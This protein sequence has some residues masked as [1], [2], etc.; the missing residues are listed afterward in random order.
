MTTPSS[1]NW[2]AFSVFLRNASTNAA[3]SDAHPLFLLGHNSF[4]TATSCPNFLNGNPLLQINEGSKFGSLWKPFDV[5][6]ST[7]CYYRSFDFC[8]IIP[9]TCVQL[10]NLILAAFPVSMR[11]PD[12][13]P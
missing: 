12:P 1:P 5:G 13:F 8:N 6:C 2:T 11:L 3:L 10:R 7:S 9:A 4:A